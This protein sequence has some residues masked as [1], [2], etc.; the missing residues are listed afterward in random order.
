MQVN[1]SVISIIVIIIVATIAAGIR[2]VSAAN[3]FSMSASLST[4][5]NIQVGMHSTSNITVTN[6]NNTLSEA[7]T[8]AD[9]PSSGLLSCSLNATL[10]TIGPLSNGFVS[11]TCLATV[12][13]TYNV[14]VTGTAGTTEHFVIVNFIFKDLVNLDASSISQTDVIVLPSASE[15][16]SFRV[17]AV[18][19][20]S[21]T[22]SVANVYG[23]QFTINYNATAFVP[24]GDPDPAGSYP[25]GAANSVLFGAQTTPGTVNWAGLVSLTQAFGSSQTSS[26][27]GIGQITVF[28]TMISP[29]P[30]Q[31]ISA[32][33]L[34]ANVNFELLNK[35]TT[36]QHFT[37]TNV[38]MTDSSL[39]ILPSVSSGVEATE[40]ITNTPPT[41]RFAVQG[42][43]PGDP[44]CVPVTGSNCTAFAF[45]FDGSTSS[46][47]ENG[48]IVSPAGFF[49][50]FGD[51][52]QDLGVT[53]AVVVHDYLA[54]G[55]FNVTLRVVDGKG[56]TGAARDS[57]GSPIVNIQPSHAILTIIAATGFTIQATPT[58]FSIGP[59]QVGVV[60]TSTLTFTSV[61]LATGT[62]SLAATSKPSGPNAPTS[63]F[64]QPSVKLPSGG[65]NSSTLSISYATAT[66]NLEYNITVSAT[67]GSIINTINVTLI[68]TTMKV[69]PAV[70]L[71]VQAN[72]QFTVSV[73]SSAV[74]LFSWQFQLNYNQTL[75]SASLSSVS[76]GPYWLAQSAAQ[77]AFT[78]RQVNQTGGTIVMTAA[79]LDKLL[80]FTG[81]TTLATIKFTVKTQGV[82][83][84]YLSSEG[85]LK[86]TLINAVGLGQ[87][88]PF[89]QQ[90]GVF[91]NISCLDHD[92][93]VS[94][95]AV[96]STVTLGKSATMNVT[97][98]NLGLNPETVTV[99]FKAGSI[100]IGS[101]Q[102]FL[103]PGNST[104]VTI[105]WNTAS[106]AAGSY[107]IT[108]QANTVGSTNQAPNNSSSGTVNV[109]QTTP[110]PPPPTIPLIYLVIGGVGA[111]AAAS[112]AFLVL[113]RRRRPTPEQ[114]T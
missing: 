50:D 59:N 114:Q 47:V 95:L 34:L 99:T 7:V 22:N 89:L 64:S 28:L 49:W 94:T 88:L 108:A 90:N 113:R 51:G 33:V 42:L 9:T 56:A 85:P 25:D 74:G 53:G 80:A 55:K 102:V 71:G 37:I 35:P 26:A 17:G 58:F 68:P 21:S 24:Q 72:S 78:F 69:H 36:P 67:L 4:V 20:A 19:N 31:T 10:L 97:I 73:T 5:D 16:K 81:N 61:N 86:A 101:K 41:A 32:K 87:P 27:G 110:S 93:I 15:P 105:V 92:V 84:L 104:T 54:S 18:V 96:P 8:V 109:V 39:N 6:T 23:W 111:A 91:C 40:T 98:A 29:N 14:N 11:V 66:P 45:R 75:L 3:E 82:T 77:K 103:I 107:T 46:D 100:D 63:S 70:V 1:R 44:S 60:A 112:A 38:I 48:T 83:A 57:L 52:T 65:S 12:L 2:P 106:L 30:A 79:L 13:G 76:F 62:I 43:P